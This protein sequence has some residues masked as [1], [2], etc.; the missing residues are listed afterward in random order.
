MPHK[1]SVDRNDAIEHI[2]RVIKVPLA[3]VSRPERMLALQYCDEFKITAKELIDYSY[4]KM[5]ER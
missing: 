1:D 4:K 5:M 2:A 3:V